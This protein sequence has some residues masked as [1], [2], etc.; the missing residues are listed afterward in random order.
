[1]DER[2]YTMKKTYL[3]DGLYAEYDGYQIELY[4]SNGVTKTNI[5]YLDSHVLH[6][7]LNWIEALKE[8]KDEMEETS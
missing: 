3:G 5:V 8:N 2:F 1:M 7:F 4:A 6:A